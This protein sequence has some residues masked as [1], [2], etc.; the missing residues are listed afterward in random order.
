MTRKTISKTELD[1]ENLRLLR[2]LTKRLDDAGIWY[3]LAYGT[4]L[5]AVR[6][7]G[8]IP[9]DTDV[10]I[11]VQFPD[12]NRIRE[13]LIK[14]PINDSTFSGRQITPRYTRIHDVI[15]STMNDAHI[16]IEPLIGAPSIKKDQ[17]RFV[18]KCYYSRMLFKSKYV[19]INDCLPQN[20]NKVKVVKIIDKFI[21]DKTIE[22]IYSMLES[23]YDFND[24]EYLTPLVNF[25]KVS[26]CMKR[27]VYLER[28]RHQFED[29][30]CYIPKAYDVYLTNIYGDYMTPRRY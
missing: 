16:D 23:K 14:N 25:G 2:E 6:H 9:W 13:I 5:G 29:M 15:E 22:R 3:T 1:N 10:D 18:K 28:I 26:S 4:M 19:D 8:F 27:E 24:A 11:Y 7:N 17:A 21:S 12:M 20:R 30:E